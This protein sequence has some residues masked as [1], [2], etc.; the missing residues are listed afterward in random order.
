MVFYI[1]KM[2]DVNYIGSCR[3]I[4]ERYYLHKRNCWNKKANRHNLLVYKFIREKNKNIE[5]EILFCYKGECSNKIQRLVEQFYIN[6][7]DSK[8]NGLNSYNAF[9]NRKI[10][11]KNYCEKNK[12]KDKNKTNNE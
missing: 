6:K 2:K 4:K 12:D 1:Y 3:N 8:N 11:E 5:L 9:T 7:Y 10:Y